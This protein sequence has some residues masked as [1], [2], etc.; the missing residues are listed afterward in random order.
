MPSQQISPPVIVTLTPQEEELLSQY[1]EWF[2]Q[3]GFAIEP[4]GG[5]EYAMTA[6]PDNLS[7]IPDRE[8]FTQM[9]DS[10]SEGNIR[11]T[12]ELLLERLAGM[13]CKAAVKGGDRLQ[14]AEAD[15]LITQLLSLENPYNCPHGRPTIISMS[16]HEL[17][18]KFKRII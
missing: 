1:R 4:F 2:E 11:P 7:S 3:L 6:V 8:L 13:S 15:A 10:L 9:L 16:R 17:D 12:P 14:A 5:R 18:R